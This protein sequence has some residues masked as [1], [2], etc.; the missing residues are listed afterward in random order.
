MK[1]VLTEHQKVLA[2]IIAFTDTVIR[3]AETNLPSSVRAKAIFKAEQIL[4]SRLM[5][6]LT[7]K[8]AE[9]SVPCVN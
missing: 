3:I 8:C 6:K 1:A 2:E 5:D 4:H 7:T 9:K